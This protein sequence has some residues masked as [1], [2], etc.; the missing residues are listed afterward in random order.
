MSRTT[1]QVVMVGVVNK[2]QR[3]AIPAG[4]PVVY[5]CEV[6]E[7]GDIEVVGGSAVELANNVVDT[8]LQRLDLPEQHLSY[9]AGKNS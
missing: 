1:N 8:I 2:G 7:G 9:L 6:Q 5:H 3:L 4:A